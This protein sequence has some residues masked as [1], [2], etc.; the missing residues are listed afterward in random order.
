MEHGATS[1]APAACDAQELGRAVGS[2]Q[3]ALR[4]SAFDAGAPDDGWLACRARDAEGMHR[5][6]AHIV[7][8]VRDVEL[9]SVRG[10]LPAGDDGARVLSDPL[11]ACPA[12]EENAEYYEKIRSPTSL[13]SITHRIVHCEYA[14][15]ALFDQDM[16]QLFANARAWYGVGAEE[17]GEMATLQRLYQQLARARDALLDARG[18]RHAKA[19]WTDID[20][21]NALRAG[22]EPRQGFASSPYGPGYVPPDDAGCTDAVRQ[23]DIAFKG[24]RYRVGD[25]VHLMNPVDA[26]RPIVGQIFRVYRRP[27]V[28]GEFLTACWYYRPEQT[29]HVE[30]R[31]FGEHELVKTGIYGEHAVEDILE[32]VLVLFHTTYTCARPQAAFVDRDVPVYFV[33][34]KYDVGR[35]AFHRIYSWASCVPAEVRGAVTPMDVFPRRAAQPAKRPSLLAQGVDVRG[36]RLVEYAAPGDEDEVVYAAPWPAPGPRAAAGADRRSAAAGADGSSGAAVAGGPADAA[37][38]DGRSGAAAPPPVPAPA[39]TH[40]DRLLAYN[41]FHTVA[42][43]L[44]R[45]VAPAVYTDLQTSL[46]ARPHA[47]PGELTALAVRAGVP[48]ALLV[49]LRDAALATGVLRAHDGAEPARATSTAALLVA[50]HADASF[51]RLPEKTSSLFRRD[52]AGAVLWCP[53]VPMD[54]W[55]A[56]LLVLDGSCTVPLPSLEYMYWGS[57]RGDGGGG[58]K[59]ADGGPG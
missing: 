36:G 52:A 43:D 6:Y 56:E 47:S 21:V 30:D 42:S 54:G 46:A 29:E 19:R 48:N 38:A 25:W 2:G 59:S 50:H 45:R 1:A 8:Y 28:P 49:A 20:V 18:K 12:L 34:H 55:P 9:R 22:A 44:A 14:L 32:D 10:V 5:M 37:E 23:P 17:Y 51:G 41:H 53:S 4:R 35:Q 39:P 57:G 3:C 15:P 7:H 13:E 16:L 40:P 24:R 26:S 33:Q 31:L 11:E 27:H 58:Q